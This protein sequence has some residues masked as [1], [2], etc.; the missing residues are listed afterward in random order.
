MD[1]EQAI[2]LVFARLQFCRRIGSECHVYIRMIVGR[3]SRGAVW[4]GS[5]GGTLVCPG[6]NTC[7]FQLSSMDGLSAIFMDGLSLDAGC[8]TRKS[9]IRLR[10]A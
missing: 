5:T 7:S 6:S 4:A 2:D 1:E 10:V 8:V 9:H 3:Y